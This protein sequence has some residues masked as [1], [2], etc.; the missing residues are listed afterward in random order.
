MTA[1]DA[2]GLTPTDMSDALVG[3][4]SIV[5]YARPGFGKTLQMAQCFSGALW[6]CTNKGTLRPYAHWCETNREVVESLGLRTILAP[7]PA[8]TPKKAAKDPALAAYLPQSR[9]YADGGMMIKVV[10]EFMP[11][12]KTPV[13]N[14]DLIQ[15]I[16]YRFSDSRQKGT[17]PYTGIIFDEGTEFARRIHKQTEKKFR[18]G[19]QMWST[20]EDWLRW[21][22]Q[23]PRGANCMLGFI[24]HERAPKY[25]ED[26][27]K[28]RYGDL[29]HVGG[30]ALPSRGI[31]S[32]LTGM[33]DIVLH[34]IIRDTL[35]GPQRIWQT[36][37]KREWES[38]LRGEGVDAESTDDIATLLGT[39]GYDVPKSPF[40]RP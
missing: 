3:P 1:R 20:L 8:W 2:L 35:D 4:P 17:C 23:V 27:D 28:P 6:V 40:A 24:C 34:G 12:N 25:Q 37:P 13:D 9:P 29:L 5:P 7:N 39:L 38:K 36:Q 21:L 26:E 33:C 16:V 11:D 14:I 22:F 30:P 31:R 19:F 32:A 10:P 15:Q 18:S